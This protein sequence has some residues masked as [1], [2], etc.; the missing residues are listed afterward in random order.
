MTEI[1]PQKETNALPAALSQ[2]LSPTQWWQP[3]VALH[4]LWNRGL[5][6]NV[7]IHSQ[8]LW[9]L[10]LLPV[11]FI[12]QI[13]TPHP[14]WIVL[15]VALLGLYGI[16]IVWVRAQAGHIQVERQRIGTILV[17]GDQL[18]EV[19]VLSNRSALPVL[20]AEVR[21]GSTL[22]GY[23]AG[24]VVGCS[25]NTSYRWN[26]K[27]TCRQRGL[28]Q[29]GPHQLHLADPLGFFSLTIDFPQAETI[30]IYPRVLQLPTV[31]LPQGSQNSTAQRRR[32]LYGAQPASTVRAYQPTDSLRHVHWPITAH[33]GALMVKE[34]ESEPSGTVWI[35][36]D[37]D[38]AM[39]RGEGEHDTLEYSIVVA[40][41]LTAALLQDEERRTVGLYTISGMRESTEHRVVTLAPQSGQA[42]LWTILAG[43]AP[44]VHLQSSGINSS[45]V[46]VTDGGVEPQ[47]APMRTLLAGYGI[48]V[49]Q[50]SS[51]AQLP[52][53]LTFRRTRRVIRSTPTGGAISYEVEEEVG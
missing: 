20:W 30:V 5:P 35:L 7:A 38:Q 13:V 22:P 36:L 51:H 6:P 26:N 12:N 14:I 50:L 11:V 15:L 46:L 31:V 27:F 2:R 33:R 47:E 52:P 21:D 25:G 44:L 18:E 45:V 39:R 19:F 9:P 24:Q 1:N 48:D 3:T 16:A 34:L 53:A 17:A 49:Q 43:L 37:L 10:L 29:L 23:H 32:P 8:L 40:A 4:S 41:S 28:Y 42:Q